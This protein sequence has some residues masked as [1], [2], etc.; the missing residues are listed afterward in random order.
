M[1]GGEAELEHDPEYHCNG[2]GEVEEDLVPDGEQ[3]EGAQQRH[4]HR[5][6]APHD[7]LR[8]RDH[9]QRARDNCMTF[10]NFFRFCE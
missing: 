7:E 5:Q 1:G 6:Q 9:G 4:A 8:A 2:E 10:G 3:Q